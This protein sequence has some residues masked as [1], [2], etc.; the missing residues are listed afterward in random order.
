MSYSNGQWGPPPTVVQS[1][2]DRR[3]GVRRFFSASHA[4]L[5]ALLTLGYLLPWA[6][7]ASR[8]SRGSAQ[9]FWINLLLGWTL[10]GWVIALIL[11]FRVHPQSPVIVYAP[12]RG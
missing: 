7:A 9:V 10:L 4:W 6:L 2:P 3:R 5:W 8:G 1:V 12:P 11:A